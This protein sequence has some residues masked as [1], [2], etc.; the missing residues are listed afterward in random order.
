MRAGIAW[1][2]VIFSLLVLAAMF[3]FLYSG[4]SNPLI[5]ILSMVFDLIKGTIMLF[6][7]FFLF[8]GLML[9]WL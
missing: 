7:L 4:L 1:S 6:A 3:V 5:G 2:F 9:L 8:S